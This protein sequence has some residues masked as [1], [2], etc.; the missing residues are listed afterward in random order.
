MALRAV[1]WIPI[2]KQHGC[3]HAIVVNLADRSVLTL[4]PNFAMAHAFYGV[5]LCYAGR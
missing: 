5:T 2:R 4:N 1:K 3:H